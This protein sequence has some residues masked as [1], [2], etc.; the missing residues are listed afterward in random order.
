MITTPGPALAAV[1]VGGKGRRMGGVAKGLLREPDGERT[2][3]ARA[4]DTLEACGL[5]VVLVGQSDAYGIPTLADATP[6][7]GPLA[8]LVAAL[9]RAN[10]RDLIAVACDMPYFTEP[11]VRRL[12]EAPH[13]DADAVAP[14]RDGRFEPLFARYAAACLPVA[15]RR[16]AGERRSL[17]G[18]L[19]A[20][21]TV[22]LALSAEES[23]L[24]DDWDTE[25]DVTRGR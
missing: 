5:D 24:L 10:G 4:R 15:E 18:L 16:L 20:V 3:V 11:L 19:D 13:E 22:P 17:L 8:G 2:L 1:F 25:A 21:R 12:V 9:R 7:G 6:D 23:A 14:R